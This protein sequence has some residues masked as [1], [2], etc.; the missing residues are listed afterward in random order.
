[1]SRDEVEM[2][3]EEDRYVPEKLTKQLLKDEKPYKKRKRSNHEKFDTSSRADEKTIDSIGGKS[4][5]KGPSEGPLASFALSENSCKVP[6]QNP[7]SLPSF[8]GAHSPT[9]G[10]PVT[11]PQ[12]RS[13]SPSSSKK[14]VQFDDDISDDDPDYSPSKRK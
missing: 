13:P 4:P 14:V 8:S 3:T 1:M 5:Q 10:G 12:N 2:S 11:Q 9:N 7:F 6:R